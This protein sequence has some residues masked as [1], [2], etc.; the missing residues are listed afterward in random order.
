MTPRQKKEYYTFVIP[1]ILAFA[2]GG[3]YSIV[4]GFF[5]GHCLGDPGL[6]SVT[7]GY[8]L[9]VLI[10][11]VGTGLGL[12]GAIRYTIWG[13]QDQKEEQK[14]CYTAALLLLILVSIVLTV[15]FLT[16]LYP[17][18]RFLGAEGDLLEMTAEYVR[19]LAIGTTLQLL[20]TGLIPFIRNMGGTTYA[21]VSMILGFVVNIILDYVLVWH[22]PLG[23]SG[24]AWATVIGQASTTVAAILFLLRKKPGLRFPEIREMLSIWGEMFRVAVAPFGM[25][26][27]PTIT[28]ILMNRFLLLYG[29][30][31]AVA[32]YGCVDY[33][34]AVIYLLL[35][36]VGDGSQPVI[37]EQYGEGNDAMSAAYRT[38]AYRTA[39]VITVVCMAGLYLTRGLI[40]VL[41]GASPETCLEV[42]KRL[43][44]F[45]ATLIFVAF[46]RVTTSYLYAT[47]KVALSYVLVY[48]EPVLS[49]VACL[50]LPLK[51]G[52]D[53]VWVAIPCSQVLSGVIAFVIKQNTDRR[54]AMTNRTVRH[55]EK[56]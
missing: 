40:G 39:G 5:I 54:L 34:V 29:G 31:Q 44:L 49:L 23:M 14:K 38:M 41:F 52:L 18:L 11:A 7:I 48:T 26:I 24:A 16:Q 22:I 3:V 8:P 37:S 21:M 10:Q 36:G 1:S 12:A 15:I 19:V 2:L 33:V 30:E 20:A 35:Q 43:P 50:L 55:T 42:V 45:L 32:V 28:L 51:M 4:D 53:G 56:Q 27:S 25:T 17:I 47:E 9:A 46:I 6:A 13:A